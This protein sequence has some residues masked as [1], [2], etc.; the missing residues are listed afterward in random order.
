MS[1]LDEV[2]KTIQKKFGMGSIITV[3]DYKKMN[4]ETISTGLISLD[5]ALGVGGIPRGKITEIF[6][7]E[8]SGK[9]SLS[10]MIIAQA[11][12]KNNKAALIDVEHSFD[13]DY[14]KRLGVN[15]D[16]LIVSQPDNGEQALEIVEALVKSE[17][18]AVVVIDSVAALVPKKEL[19]GDYGDAQMGS[20]ARMMSQGMRKLMGV[21]AKTN[22][23][24][25]F[26]N[27]IRMKLGVLWGNPETTTGGVALKYYSSV[28][29]ELK[30]SKQIKKDGVHIGYVVNAKVVK[31]KVAPP[32]KNCVLEMLDDEDGF[33]IKGDVFSMGQKYDLIT[34]VGN[35]WY[36][37]KEKLGVGILNAIQNVNEKKLR[38]EILEAWHKQ[39][40]L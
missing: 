40:N 24:V 22:T 26:L 20:M 39:N 15:T 2:I 29:I 14:A 23:S 16:D 34:K 32:F 9:S 8:M 36:Y 4:V 18:V 13:L 28:R 21:I 25:I 31:N 7:K 35:T 37:G 17:E 6:G 19:E 3:K 27:Q 11:Q 33:S 12:K 1:N 5:L 10:L 38:K 30:K